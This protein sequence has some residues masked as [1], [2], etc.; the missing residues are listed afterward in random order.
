MRESIVLHDDDKN[1]ITDDITIASILN[2]Y[3]VNIAN[4][5]NITP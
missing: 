4:D 1:V 2:T 5:L 3:F